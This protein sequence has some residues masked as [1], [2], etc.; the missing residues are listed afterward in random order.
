MICR[1]FKQLIFPRYIEA[2][3]ILTRDELVYDIEFVTNRIA[4]VVG[5][6]EEGDTTKS[7]SIITAEG[8]DNVDYID[9][10]IVSA[11]KELRGRTSWASGKRG[12][13]VASDVIPKNVE[14]WT[15]VFILPVDWR[16]NGDVLCSRCHDY[17]KWSVISEWLKMVAPSMAAT[18][19]TNANDALDEVRYE[20]RKQKMGGPVFY[21]LFK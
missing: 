5:V 14:D 6:D 3:V 18:Y 8:K 7:A 1:L 19:E 4:R 17:V 16:G 20:L 9:R 13:R 12:G 2:G 21:N 11:V 15:L 10:L